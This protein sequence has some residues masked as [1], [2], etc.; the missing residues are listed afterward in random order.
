MPIAAFTIVTCLLAFPD[1]LKKN[2]YWEQLSYLV[3]GTMLAF[4]HISWIYEGLMSGNVRYNG[5]TI[6]FCYFKFTVL[7][8]LCC[9]KYGSNR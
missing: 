1:N 5:Y 7:C 6:Q 2:P 8:S 4:H 3:V 9:L